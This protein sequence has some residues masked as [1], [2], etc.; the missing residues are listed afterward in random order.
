MI[1]DSHKIPIDA[2]L[3]ARSYMILENYHFGLAQG[4]FLFVR[5]QF[6]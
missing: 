3:D 5:A 1:L 2:K 6:T 4:M